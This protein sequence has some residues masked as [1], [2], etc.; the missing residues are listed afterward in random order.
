MHAPWHSLSTTHSCCFRVPLHA[1][2]LHAMHFPLTWVHM[3]STIGTSCSAVPTKRFGSS[4]KSVLYS[5]V[6]LGNWNCSLK[7]GSTTKS[8]GIRL[9]GAA[10]VEEAEEPAEGEQQQQRQQRAAVCQ[11]RRC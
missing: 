6:A 7:Q 3:S 2:L 1:F 10:A 9:S 4:W 11:G 5:G 8:W